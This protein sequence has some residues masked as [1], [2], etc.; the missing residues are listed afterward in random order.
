MIR[1]EIS[2]VILPMSIIII[3]V[4]GGGDVIL[5]S[6]DPTTHLQFLFLADETD[7]RT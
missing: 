5:A 3:I 1:V 7:H 4:C 2:F 6:H